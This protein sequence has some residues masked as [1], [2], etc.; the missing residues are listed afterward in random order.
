MGT[1]LGVLQDSS[2]VAVGEKKDGGQ[3]RGAEGHSLDTPTPNV[4]SGLSFYLCQSNCCQARLEH[5]GPTTAGRGSCRLQA[6]A[7]DTSLN[8]QGARSRGPSQRAVPRCCSLCFR[9]PS[10]SPGRSLLILQVLT[11]NATCSE[12]PSLTPQPRPGALYLQ[13][14]LSRTAARAGNEV[15]CPPRGPQA[16]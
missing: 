1:Y 6:R 13:L 2:L 9:C 10:L 3:W 16:P 5:S 14:A 12:K 15:A 8:L 11:S 7:W 4:K